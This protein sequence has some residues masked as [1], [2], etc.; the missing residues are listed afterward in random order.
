[1]PDER[2]S[3]PERRRAALFVGSADNTLLFGRTRDLST[4]GIF[5]E[6]EGRPPIGTAL[7]IDVAWGDH[8]QSCRAEVVRHA[9]NGIALRF[10]DPEP[11]FQEAL[12][13][14]ISSSPTVEIV[15]GH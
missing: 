5:L 9:G 7:N 15:S 14:I 1:M 10:I 6:T 3:H 8:V 4:T 13:E 11:L 2:R 12:R